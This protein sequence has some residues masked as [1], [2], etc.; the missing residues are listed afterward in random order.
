[1]LRGAFI[2][3]V[4]AA[5]G[6]GSRL[7]WYAPPKQSESLI[8]PP[9]VSFGCFVAMSDPNASAYIVGGFRD[10]SEGP[11]RW[12]HEHPVLQFYVPRV[13]R[14]RLLIDLTFPEQT[15]NQTGAVEVVI[16][17]NG[18]EFDRVRYAKAGNEEYARA[19]PWKWLHARA[20]NTVA[21]DP[22]KTAVGPGGERLGFV[23][24]RAGFVE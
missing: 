2:L 10:Q 6:C 7:T 18:R 14:L 20:I 9:P 21:L 5:V 24:T 16:R 4:L 1:V 13:P 12:T 11:W 3:F 8:T 15:F 23:V 19:T 22:D 17:I